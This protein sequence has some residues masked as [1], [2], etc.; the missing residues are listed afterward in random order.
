MVLLGAKFAFNAAM[1]C[2]NYS[3]I[4][5]SFF[6]VH[7]LSVLVATYS[8]ADI[9]RADVTTLPL[10][11]CSIRSVM[12]KQRRQSNAQHSRYGGR[13]SSVITFKAIAQMITSS[14]ETF[15]YKFVAP[16]KEG[17]DAPTRR[18]GSPLDQNGN[19]TNPHLKN[20]LANPK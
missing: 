3:R 7:R 16:L 2:R 9:V 17:E 1:G 5:T 4:F 15:V 6:R 19:S 8:I 18:Y 20:P 12:L 10:H 11:G 14:N 13:F